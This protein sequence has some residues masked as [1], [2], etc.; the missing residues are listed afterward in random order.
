MTAIRVLTTPDTA[1]FRPVGENDRHPTKRQPSNRNTRQE[2]T[3]R[4]PAPVRIDPARLCRVNRPVKWRT[5]PGAE[6]R[7][8]DRDARRRPQEMHSF[9]RSSF[10][11]WIDD[12]AGSVSQS[13]SQAE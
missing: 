12:E 11:G 9:S 10:A 3:I 4:I 7:T 8:Y 6:N 2:P 1:R 5:W 13:C